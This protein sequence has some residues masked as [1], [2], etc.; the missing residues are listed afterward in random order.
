[1]QSYKKPKN[2]RYPTPIEYRAQAY[3]A[4]LHGAKGLMWYGGSVQ[5]GAYL[6]VEESNWDYLKK[7]A[8][9]MKDMAPV[10]MAPAQPAPKFSPPDAPVSVMLKK[11]GERT[12][13]IAVNR[14]AKPVEVTFE[15][16]GVKAKVLFENRDVAMS[17][18]KLT[19]KFDAYAVH[20]YEL[21]GD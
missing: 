5:G 6:N 1:V 2:G 20:V 9:E 15:A 7:L 17:T 13:L 8:A 4:L 21:K 14:G 3:I 12:V 11:A 18:G 16:A 10:F 19:D